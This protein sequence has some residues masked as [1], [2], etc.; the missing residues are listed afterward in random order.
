MIC[1]LAVQFLFSHQMVGLRLQYDILPYH[2][3]FVGRNI[4]TI[5][6][7]SQ[8][9][10]RL[11]NHQERETGF[12]W[13]PNLEPSAPRHWRGCLTKPLWGGRKDSRVWG[14][15][16]IKLQKKHWSTKGTN[17]VSNE[18]RDDRVF[19]YSFHSCQITLQGTVERSFTCIDV[20]Q[21]IPSK[22]QRYTKSEFWIENKPA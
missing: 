15:K 22:H 6:W 21:N 4:A 11:S 5:D 2:G 18:I 20:Y 1:Q 9:I 3:G 7:A 10:T 16:G 12:K 8:T 19:L 13:T 17:K 14:E